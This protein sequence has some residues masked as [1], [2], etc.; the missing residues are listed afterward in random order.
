MAS[1]RVKRTSP[2]WTTDCHQNLC[3]VFSYGDG[4][5]EIAYSPDPEVPLTR[6]VITHNSAGCKNPNHNPSMS[7]PALVLASKRVKP[8]TISIPLPDDWHQHLRDV[9]SNGDGRLETV[10]PI[11]AKHFGRALCMPNIVPPVTTTELALA[12]RERVLAHAP[13]G[14]EPLMTLYLTE[15]TKPE[16]MDKLKASMGKVVACKLVSFFNTCVS[17]G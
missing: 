16:E 6:R 15:Q 7:Q 13:K 12:Y 11:V 2:N 5:L 14:F 3:D 17:L 9:F 8:T 1:K 4:H 10:T